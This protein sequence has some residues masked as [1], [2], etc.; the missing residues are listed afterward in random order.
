[1]E[2]NLV[3]SGDMHYMAYYRPDTKHEVRQA[4]IALEW[5]IEYVLSNPFK[6]IL[7]VLEITLASCL[8]MNSTMEASVYSTT[9]RISGTFTSV[10]SV[11]SSAGTVWYCGD[12]PACRTD[13]GSCFN[14]ASEKI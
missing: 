8:D 10:G 3:P 6:T 2:L 13:Y 7:N 1:M 14:C 11:H 4:D 9:R 5:T 12:G